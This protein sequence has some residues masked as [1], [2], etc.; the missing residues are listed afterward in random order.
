[1]KPTDQQLLTRIRAG[2]RAAFEQLFRTTYPGLLRFANAQ[3]G[4]RAEAED[5]VQDV[6]VR[7]WNRREQ[8]PSAVAPRSYLL[9]AVRNRVID[10]VRR[11]ALERRWLEPLVEPEAP[12]SKH[13]T[14]YTLA[15][16]RVE[17]DAAELAELH[18]AIRHAIA[19]LPER[20]RTAFLLCRDQELSYAEAAEVMGV[21]PA[22]VKTQVARALASLRNTLR[23]FLL[24][25]LT[26]SSWVR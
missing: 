17:S 13:N 16:R 12:G 2:D 8:L 24:V 14:P 23:P 15:S 6:F 11:R 10:R 1:M 9:A 19:A 18:G 25:L 3:L 26:A 5:V 20:C 21:T 22:T 7:V 4:N